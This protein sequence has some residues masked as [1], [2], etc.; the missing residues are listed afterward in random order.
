M[1]ATSRD[2][3][4]RTTRMDVVAGD[5]GCFAGH[6]RTLPRGSVSPRTGEACSVAATTP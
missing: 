2:D 1:P 3:Y 6:D 4:D 5:P